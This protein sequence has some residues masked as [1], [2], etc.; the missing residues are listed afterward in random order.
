MII[1]VDFD[2]TIVESNFPTIVGE[3]PGAL[4]ALRRLAEAGH[5]IIIWTCRYG[6][7]AVDAVNWLLENNVEFH[8]FN[9][10]NPENM[11]KFNNTSSRKVYADVYIDDK[12]IGG[13]IGWDKVIDILIPNPESETFP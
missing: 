1:A 13:F 4:H 12:N 11:K 5:Y 9:A 6:D 10:P 3:I 7:D 2:L 8:R